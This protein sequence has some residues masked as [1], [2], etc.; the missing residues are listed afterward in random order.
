M[1]AYLL[2]LSFAFSM[3]CLC[4]T[5]VSAADSESPDEILTKVVKAYEKIDDYICRFSQ[6]ELANG[7]IREDKNLVLK[8]KKPQ[9]IY[10]RWTEG[11]DKG[12]ESIYVEGKN[13]NKLVVHLNGF[14]K[15]ITVSLDPRNSKA[16]KDRRHP[17]TEAGIGFIVKMMADNYSRAQNDKD[18]VISKAEDD[19]VGGRKAIKIDA[20]FPPDK[21]YYN[22]IITI[23]IDRELFLPVKIVVYGKNKEFLEEYR[24][25]D[26][27]IGA[28]LKDKDFDTKNPDYNF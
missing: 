12:I 21:G 15:F 5:D 24:F 13:K 9:H 3:L 25:E 8:F 17:I 27:R 23:W 2:A 6:K 4:R 19:E 26:I 16:M 18:C 7:K 20:T 10:L 22:H 14:W 1:K 28:G 11:N